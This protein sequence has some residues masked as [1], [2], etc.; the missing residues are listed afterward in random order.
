MDTSSTLSPSISEAQV[1][2]ALL[3]LTFASFLMLIFLCV[4]KTPT[5][6]YLGLC[7][8]GGVAGI[9]W[10][11][12]KVKSWTDIVDPRAAT[13]PFPWRRIGLQFVATCLILW[14]RDNMPWL[15]N[16]IWCGGY[17]SLGLLMGLTLDLWLRHAALPRSSPPS[18]P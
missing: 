3:G 14:F 12:V 4:V 15:N 13:R 11:R 10:G 7:A 1:Q 5:P 2:N 8:A 16:L 9:V 6:L 17:A 18:S